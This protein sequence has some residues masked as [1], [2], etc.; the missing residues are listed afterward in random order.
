AERPGLAEDIPKGNRYDAA[1]LAALAGC[2]RGDDAAGLD[3]DQ[4]AFWRRQAL[5][6]LR[7]DLMHWRKQ[8]ENDSPPVRLTVQKKLEHWQ[9]DSDLSGVRG[10]AAL[11]A[12]PDAE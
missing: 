4:R 8:V 9:R 7:A 2:G 10:E 11:A 3:A 12:L 5:E 1:C 6:W